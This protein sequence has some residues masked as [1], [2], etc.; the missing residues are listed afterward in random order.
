M[1]RP[2]T[3]AEYKPRS[4]DL[5]FGD[6]YYTFALGLEQIAE[7]QEKC[8]AGI[9]AIFARVLA[10]RIL[11]PGAA[12]KQVGIPTAGAYR[13]ED[14]RET[15]RLGLI[16]GGMKPTDAR[17]MVERYVDTR[18]IKEAWDIGASILTALIEGFTPPESDGV[19]GEAEAAAKDGSISPR[20]SA[21]V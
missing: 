5:Y 3:Q 17:V 15:T 9:G 19:S 7:L 6:A 2:E 13:Y 18:P 14:L 16:G 12:R 21:T 1:A 20:P 4:V 10:G 8:G 11:L